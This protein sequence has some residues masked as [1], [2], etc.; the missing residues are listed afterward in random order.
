[1]TVKQLIEILQ[2]IPDQDTRVMVKG[3]ERGYDDIND[4]IPEP[5]TIALNVN[6]KWYYGKHDNI[7]NIHNKYIDNLTIVKAIILS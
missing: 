6:D 2:Q 1:M 7:D 3:Y 4:I 5:I